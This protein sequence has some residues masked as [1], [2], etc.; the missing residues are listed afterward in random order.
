LA[1]P[2]FYHTD[3]VRPSQWKFI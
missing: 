2:G 1:F 3:P